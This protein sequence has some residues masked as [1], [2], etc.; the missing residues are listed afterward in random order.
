[1]IQTW[2]G[3]AGRIYG[4][5]AEEAIGRP[6]DMLVPAGRKHEEQEILERMRR[7]ERV[8]HLETMRIRKDGREIRVSISMSPIHDG[9]G[10]VIGASQIS[11]DITAECEANEAAAR[12]AALVASSSDA[13]IGKTL[14]GV[15]QSWNAG[16][17]RVYGYTAR[18]MAGQS[19][20]LL[21]P[22]NRP[23]EESAILARIQRGESVDHFE[24]ERVRK[25][26]Q[27]IQVSVTI[28]PI[29]DSSG[30]IVGASHVARDISERHRF[31]SQLRQTQKLES[32]GV[33]AGGVAH[34]FNNLLTGILG[35]ASLVLDNLSPYSPNRGALE[36][37]VQAS[38]RAADLTRQ[39]LAYAGKGRFLTQPVDLSVAGARN[40]LAHSDLH[41]EEGA[42]PP[43]TGEGHAA[44]GSGCGPAAADR[45]ESGDQWSRSCRR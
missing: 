1:M 45:D 2:S 24:T 38:Q 36:E 14:K 42:A 32:L 15:I 13:I 26:G 33:L 22:S 8:N 5:S 39:L 20:T 3:G 29:R 34:D 10:S 6:I 41:P 21:L 44:R 7:G 23:D 27:V 37:V 17:E 12:L 18:E 4:Y 28:S 31:E 35:N 19:M 9:S 16:A 30:R 25:G 11:R 40:R 43:S